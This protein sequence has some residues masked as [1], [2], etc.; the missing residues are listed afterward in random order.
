MKNV[1]ARR[2]RWL[3]LLAL[4]AL[5]SGIAVIIVAIAGQQHAAS[6]SPSA[7]GTI[8]GTSDAGATPTP[9]ISRA[10][11][12]SSTRGSGT[13]RPSATS[14]PAQTQPAALPASDPVRI[15]IPAI[16][17]DSTVFPIGKDASGGLQAPQPGPNLNNVGW[18]KYSPTPG[19]AGPAVLEGHV[20]TIHGPSVFLRLGALNPG[21]RITVTRADGS[22]ARFVVDAVRAYPSHD[23]FPTQ[24]VYGG[25]LSQPTLR[26]ITCSNFD[27]SIG[28][29][30][31]NTIV[32]AH[33]VGGARS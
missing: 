27:R 14:A 17:V 6:P 23:A 7:W 20:D 25:D 10:A 22:V 32:F 8:P 1:Q 15:S 31:G 21:D 11:S 26:L 9:T 4:T 16:G 12:P 5:A 30:V 28:H 19:Q 29:Y 13:P 3:M 33:L 2:G 24:L 18:Y